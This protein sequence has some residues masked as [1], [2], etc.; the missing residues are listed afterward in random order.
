MRAGHPGPWGELEYTRIAIEPPEKEFDAVQLPPY[1]PSPW[2]FPHYTRDQVADL[3]RSA[4]LT[5]QES[6]S[7]QTHLKWEDRADGVA[8]TP[9]RDL[10]LSLGSKARGTI[11]PVLGHFRENPHQA[12]PFPF[13]PEFLDERLE[14]SGLS[15]AT[16]S[17]FKRL[18][19]PKGRSVFF[20]DADAYISSI[21]DPQERLRFQKTISRR[22]TL[23][24]KLKI[25]PSSPIAQIEE[26]WDYN[27]NNRELRPL[28]ESLAR[29]P[30]GCKIDIAHLLPPFARKRIYSFA[31]HSNAPHA[32][33]HNCHWSALNFFNDKADERFCD[34]RIVS[35]TIAAEYEPV[36]SKPRFGDI[37]EFFYP[38]GELIHS[39]V[40]LADDIVF[41]KNG[42]S[43]TQPYIYMHMD[44]VVDYYTATC[45]PD[46]PPSVAFLRKKQ[47]LAA[48]N[49]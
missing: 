2:V 23:L 26:Y 32:V 6:I 45:P 20:A 48:T 19:Y 30:G 38:G 44:D 29:V 46:S 3:F 7:L 17:G 39:A 49:P 41:T 14:R 28:L 25:S 42:G 10:I 13:R 35:E 8:V 16:I 34:P 22:I 15:Q 24:V 12:Q 5:S 27:G 4:G 43:D 11:Y 1:H 18:L 36:T 47:K 9:D 37:V 31:E 33:N 21:E 40:Y